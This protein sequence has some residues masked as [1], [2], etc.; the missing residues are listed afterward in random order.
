MSF[1][2]FDSFK[3]KL[4]PERS[5]TQL[6]LS[7]T[8]VF[9]RLSW[10]EI[11]IVEHAVHVRTFSPKEAIFKQGDPGSGM[12]I[13]I[14]GSV[15]IYLDMPN[16]EPKLLSELGDG[17]FFGEIALL[18][19][20]PRS[21]AAIAQEHS[22]IIGFYRPDLMDMLKTKPALGSKILLSLSEVSATRLRSTN[23]ELVKSARRIEELLEQ[24]HA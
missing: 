17:D 14:E 18:D 10:Q 5:Q 19:E 23:A 20:S 7:K 16:H 24:T 2:L 9:Q 21:A 12:Y 6:T 15:G 3:D 22:T 4:R 8:F 13:I 1:P 11:K